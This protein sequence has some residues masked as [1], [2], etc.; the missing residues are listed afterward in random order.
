MK[1]KEQSGPDYELSDE[2]DPRIWSITSVVVLGPLMTSLDSTVVNVSL[3]ALGHELHVPLNTIQWVTTGYL[4]ALALMLP[5]SGW[6]VDRIGAKRV[7]LWCFTAFTLASLLCG[8]STSAAALIAARV[9]QGMAGGLIAP[10]A[11]MMVARSAGRHVAKVMGFMVVPVLLGPIF[12][13]TLAGAILQHASWRWIFFINLPI[14]ILATALAA[15]ILPR[16]EA[17]P[18]ARGFDLR[19]FLLLSPGLVLLLYSLEKLGSG[20]LLWLWCLFLLG[21]SI[22]LLIAFVVYAW[23]HADAAL[24]DLH[25]FKHRTFSAAAWTQFLANAIAFGGQML[26]PLY[27]LSVQRISPQATGMLLASTGLGMLCSYPSMGALTARFG[28]RRVSAAGALIALLGTLPFAM[29]SF[30]GLPQWAV[31]VA[32]FVRGAGQGAISIPSI[33]AAYSSF[34]KQTI[35]AATTAINIVQRLGGPVATT[36]LAT[37][38]HARTARTLHSAV[39]AQPGWNAGAYSATFWLLCAFHAATVVAAL[40]LPLWAHKQDAARADNNRQ[41]VGVLAE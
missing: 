17:S 3:V 24:L 10:M 11:Q 29:L 2:M 31:C 13:P 22:C 4:L 12:G 36:V 20:S 19:G 8:A 39:A 18:N 35:P 37:F 15:W 7:Y 1:V 16:E 14:G 32:L 34:A 26:L 38:L 40:R 23:R 27:L 33:V 9:L 25:L 41:T 5:L 6:L 21:V 30:P 28:S